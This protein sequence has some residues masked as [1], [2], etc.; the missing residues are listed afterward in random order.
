VRVKV[1]Q[2]NIDSVVVAVPSLHK[3]SIKV[4]VDNRDA[5]TGARV[6]VAP[7]QKV[8]LWIHAVDEDGRTIQRGDR[9]F[10]FDVTA[11]L[12]SGEQTWRV[13]VVSYVP[14]ESSYYA[15]VPALEEGEYQLRLT[16]AFGF[17]LN[18]NTNA[19]LAAPIVLVV[20]SSKNLRQ[21]I[22]GG[23]CGC[24]VA[25]ACF[26][27]VRVIKRNRARAK[28]LLLSLLRWEG[29]IVAEVCLEFFDLTGELCAICPDTTHLLPTND[30]R[31]EN[32]PRPVIPAS[33][34]QPR[35]V[36][37]VQRAEYR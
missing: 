36:D 11:K 33:L 2:L 28:E 9:G 8:Q 1:T 17:G 29:I 22:V 23:V 14:A 4:R 24:L 21:T 25:L 19:S 6:E 35:Q 26:A 34:P 12:K 15:E 30:G 13:V 16:Q 3:S 27:M 32:F 37:F 5:N 10:D 20:D 18:N 31:I 7:G